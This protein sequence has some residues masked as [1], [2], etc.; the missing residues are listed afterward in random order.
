[1]IRGPS[2][3][4]FRAIAAACLAGAIAVP[5]PRADAQAVQPAV[6]PRAEPTAA[7]T[8]MR[9]QLRENAT[10]DAFILELLR[11]VRRVDRDGNGLDQAEIA[12]E[13]QRGQAQARAHALFRVFRHDL[14]GDGIVE[15]TEIAASLSDRDDS[16]VARETQ[17]VLEGHDGNR[18]GRITLAELMGAGVEQAQGDHS[19]VQLRT[20]LALDP[21][22]DGHLT[23]AELRALGEAMFASVDR[24]GDGRISGAESRGPDPVR[25]EP[26]PWV[27]TAMTQNATTSCALPPVP[28]DARLILFGAYASES[29]SSAA[30]GGQGMETHHMSVTIEPGRQPLYLVL[31]SYESMVWQLSGDVRRVAR[32]VVDSF[33]IAPGVA[34]S[35]VVGLPA[36]KVTILRGRCLQF[37]DEV[38]GAEAAR[39]IAETRRRTGRAPDAVM[40][41]YA[42]AR[43]ALPSGEVTSVRP[44]PQAPERPAPPGFDADMWRREVLR[45][46][47]NGIVEVDPR[48]VI[49]PAGAET[50]VVLPNQAGFAQLL[51]SGAIER[52]SDSRTFRIVRPIPRLPPAMAGGHSVRL[53]LVRGV[54]R[55][56]GQLDHSCMLVEDTGETLGIC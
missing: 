42:A 17:E 15:R 6:A 12:L 21:N 49:S 32:V 10:L 13:L 4:F 51:A 26:L 16:I 36:E 35:G 23:A 3:S 53:I 52:G 22:H 7:E 44:G 37:F 55:P 29:L 11:P 43:L 31:T 14:N 28:A 38:G 8:Y 47:P 20:L 2:E 19:I 5:A 46:W 18:D 45:F 34:A 40:G 41:S 24:D 30:V 9:P 1:V 50:Y 27:R 39:A 54:P 48:S 56:P 33:N 25:G